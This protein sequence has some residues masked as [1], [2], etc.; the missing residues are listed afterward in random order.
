M[1]EQ[2]DFFMASKREHISGVGKACLA[3]LL[4]MYDVLSRGCCGQRALH[5]ALFFAWKA[6]EL[7]SLRCSPR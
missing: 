6:A 3:R 1:A 4:K 7:L 5:A 2:E